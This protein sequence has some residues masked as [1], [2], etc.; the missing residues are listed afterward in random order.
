MEFIKKNYEKVLLV[1]VL[2]ALTISACLLPVIISGKRKAVADSIV[3]ITPKIKPLTNLDLTMEDGEMRRAQAPYKLDFTTKHN[4][5]NPVIWKQ[6]AD[7]HLLKEATG[8]EEGPEAL[9]VTNIKPLYLIISYGSPSASG[10]IFNIERQAAASDSKRHTAAY[11]SKGTKSELLSLT[12]VKGPADKP[13]ELDIEWN[14]GDTPQSIALTPDKPFQ[15]VEGYSADLRYPLDNKVWNDRRVGPFILHFANGSY[16]VV[17][18]TQS[19]VVVLDK[20]N[21]KKTTIAF[22]PATESR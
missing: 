19:N 3:R 12:D 7:G 18:I 5:L 1:V 13:T 8:T 2:L 4:L 16:N 21:N 11:V 9:Q 10:Y 6:M 22:H 15:Q 20:S 17:A 14:G